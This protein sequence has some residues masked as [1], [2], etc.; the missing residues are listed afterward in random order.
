MKRTYIILIVIA[1]ILM[2]ILGINLIKNNNADKSADIKTNTGTTKFTAT[3]KN[4]S[5]SKTDKQKIEITLLDINKNEIGMMYLSVP[6]LLANDTAEISSEDLK[7]YDN[8]YDF[9]IK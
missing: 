6:S 5:G 8:I 3:I 4:I 9:K 7:V 2:V 1:I